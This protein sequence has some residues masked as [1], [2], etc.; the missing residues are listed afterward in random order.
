MRT[1]TLAAALLA[2]LPAF[3]GKPVTD[4]IDRDRYYDCLL[5]YIGEAKTDAAVEVIN[6]AC[7]YKARR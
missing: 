1:L 3:A 5:K 6:R 2:C 7:L 4:P